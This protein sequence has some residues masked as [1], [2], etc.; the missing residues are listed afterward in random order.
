MTAFTGQSLNGPEGSA[1]FLGLADTAVDYDVETNK[2]V[3][4]AGR[5]QG[6]AFRFGKGKMVALAEAGMIT[7]QV[8]GGNKQLALNVMR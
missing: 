6:V 5:S 2:E 4:A 1:A 3:S 8:T 7:A